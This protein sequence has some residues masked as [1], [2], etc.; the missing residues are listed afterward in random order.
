MTIQK[1][2]GWT[3]TQY[4]LPER[5]QKVDWI[6]PGGEQVNGG[7]FQGGL[8]WYPPDSPMYVYYTPAFWRPAKEQND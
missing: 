6:S 7:T 1:I 5:G 3:N 8:I 2:D 4:Q